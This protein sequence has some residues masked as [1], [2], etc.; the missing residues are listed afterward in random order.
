[1]GSRQTIVEVPPGADGDE[2]DDRHYKKRSDEAY[3]VEREV[4]IDVKVVR[5]GLKDE[6]SSIPEH[7][8]GR[9][10]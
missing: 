7:A 4:L 5:F 10:S 2:V 3:Q 9:R 1:M 8:H 6:R